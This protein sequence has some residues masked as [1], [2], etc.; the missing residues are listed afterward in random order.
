MHPWTHN[1]LLPLICDDLSVEGQLHARILSFFHSVLNS[2]NLSVQICGQLALQGSRSSVCNNVNLV[3]SKYSL[4]K[5]EL[6]HASKIVHRFIHNQE[7]EKCK[8]E[9]LMV[10]G[11]ISDLLLLRDQ[12]DSALQLWE[13]TDLLTFLGTS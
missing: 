11:C 1:A 7:L 4:N 2:T 9:Q 6:K 8:E 12:G 5:Y 10:S 3:C 13:I